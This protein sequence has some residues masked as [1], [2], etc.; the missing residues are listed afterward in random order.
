MAAA[1][2]TTQTEV[3]H[4]GGSQSN[5]PPFDASTF[6]S[7][8]LWFVIA[9]G[10]L[11]WFM[12]KRALPADRQGDRGPQGA[13]RPRPRRRDG[14]AAESGRRGGRPRKDARRGARQ[15]PGA[16][17]GGARPGSRPRPTPSARRSRT[18][19]PAKIAEAEK[20]IAGDPRPGDDQCRRHRARR[21]RRDRRAARRTRRRS[22]GGQRPRSS[23]VRVLSGERTMEFDAEFYVLCGFIV[24][25]GLLVYLGAHR[26]VLKALDARGEAIQTELARGRQAAQRG[27]G[28]SCELREE[29][30]PRPRPTPPRSSPRRTPRPSSWR[31]TRP[32]G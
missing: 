5:F 15:R 14:D 3:G 23:Q 9:F 1:P 19:S 30:A 4:E 6:P 13:D 7:Q 28:A 22:R 29:E 25:V 31:R 20:Q 2:Q 18:S 12:S 16:R 10:F 26:T 27:D 11:Y 32:S 17:P 21:G 8:L 24:F